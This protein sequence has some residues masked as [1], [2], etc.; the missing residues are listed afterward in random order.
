MDPSL[1]REQAIG[2]IAVRDEGGRLEAR[3]LPRR[4]LLHL[5]G[6]A[7]TLGPT[8]VHAEKHLGPVLGIRPA[9]AGAHGH[10]RIAA[11]VGAVEKSR[12]LEG[13]KALLDRLELGFE[14]PGQLGIVR[15]QLGELIEVG[16]VGLE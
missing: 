10:H 13:G 2:I 9:R 14:L 12:L 11:V 16:Y 8:Q 6:E 5:H 7:A 3:L 15:R 4:G 1:G